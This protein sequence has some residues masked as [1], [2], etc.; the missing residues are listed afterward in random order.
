VKEISR[1]NEREL[2]LNVGNSSWHD[3]Y[4]HS[5]YIYVG[6]LDFELTE[7]DVVTI[8]SQFGEGAFSSFS[9]LCCTYMCI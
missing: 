5:A 9:R 1:I 6:G 7:G 2:A 4:K 8:F 3:Q